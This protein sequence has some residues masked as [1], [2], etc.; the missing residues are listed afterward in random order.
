M[1]FSTSGRRLSNSLTLVEGALQSLIDALVHPPLGLALALLFEVARVR[2]EVSVL[3]DHI[4]DLLD[5]KTVEA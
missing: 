2:G 4:P 1:S 5:T 3:I